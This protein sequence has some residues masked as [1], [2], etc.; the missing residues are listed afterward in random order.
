[1][2]VFGCS[3]EE[4]GDS[5]RGACGAL[6]ASLWQ[7]AGGGRWQEPGIPMFSGRGEIRGG[8]W[9]GVAWA[10]PLGRGAG[11]ALLCERDLSL[12]PLGPAHLWSRTSRVGFFSCLC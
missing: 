9:A 3:S 1:M 6:R 4:G 7:R 8:F 11:A 10:V 5:W 2:R 12:Q